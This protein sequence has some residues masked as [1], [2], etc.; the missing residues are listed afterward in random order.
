[1]SARIETL[2]DGTRQRW[3]PGDDHLSGCSEGDGV[4]ICD[5][6]PWPLPK[7]PG[8]PLQY[9]AKGPDVVTK[10]GDF[11]LFVQGRAA[12]YPLLEVHGGHVYNDGA[13]PRTLKEWWFWFGKGHWENFYDHAKPE[14][15]LIA[16]ADPGEDA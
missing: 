1:M 7:V 15:Y 4:C 8:L 6:G 3:G 14:C 16:R 9:L 2:P 11:I 13:E 10:D 12:K 5:T